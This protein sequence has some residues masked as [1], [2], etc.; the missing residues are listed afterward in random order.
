M[1]AGYQI[2][3]PGNYIVKYGAFNK[4]KQEKLFQNEKE[5]VRQIA[6]DVKAQ[7]SRT[8]KQGGM[9]NKLTKSIY[10]STR[11]VG[12]KRYRHPEVKASELFVK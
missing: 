4:D 5:T 6:E 1:N 12:R 7:K 11:S 2:N 9:I 8:V 10:H 3:M